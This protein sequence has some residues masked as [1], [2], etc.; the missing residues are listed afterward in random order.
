MFL[1]IVLKEPFVANERPKHD[2]SVGREEDESE[3]LPQHVAE[4]AKKGG[5][6]MVSY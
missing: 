6:A 4:W 2:A 3:I 5:Y 1:S